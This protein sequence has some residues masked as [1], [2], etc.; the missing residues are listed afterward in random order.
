MT[1]EHI[2]ACILDE[3]DAS[4]RQALAVRCF[5]DEEL[6][7]RYVELEDNLVDDYAR[8]KLSGQDRLRFERGY[9]NRPHRREKVVMG[10]ALLRFVDKR[11]PAFARSHLM[12]DFMTEASN[13]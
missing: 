6:F 8:G 12:F 5:H 9:C 11:E 1:D 7:A 4:Q 2:I 10:A 3:T 13:P